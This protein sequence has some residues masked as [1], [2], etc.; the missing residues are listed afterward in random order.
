MASDRP[1]FPLNLM[2]G[3]PVCWL[4]FRRTKHSPTMGP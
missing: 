1:D 4:L 2:T 3:L